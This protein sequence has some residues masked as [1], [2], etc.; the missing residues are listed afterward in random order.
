MIIRCCT[1]ITDIPVS[2]IKYD[3]FFILKQL[4]NF[5]RKFGSLLFLHIIFFILQHFKIMIL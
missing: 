4:I 3:L 1:L 2:V 5:Y